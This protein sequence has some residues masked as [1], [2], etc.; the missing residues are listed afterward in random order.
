M[1]HTMPMGVRELLPYFVA[2]SIFF[3][4]NHCYKQK[5]IG[6]NYLKQYE[7]TEPL[8]FV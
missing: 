4:G 6:Y 3:A 7:F 2:D 8:Q 5:F 1:V